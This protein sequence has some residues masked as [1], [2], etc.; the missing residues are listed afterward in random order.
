MTAQ[1]KTVWVDAYYQKK[2]RWIDY[3]EATGEV[4][5]GLFGSK[6]VT[7]KKK[8]WVETN[9][10]SESLIDGRR[11]SADLEKALN[12]LAEAGYEIVQITPITSGNFQWKE[13]D[14]GY[15]GGANSYVSWGYS[16][17]EGATICAK[18]KSV[19]N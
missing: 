6:H 16:I 5:S 13:A 18:K 14:K 11:F 2:G 10:A 12:Q 1:Y 3:E 15:D 9:E 17:T 7:E 4:K 8:K 19:A